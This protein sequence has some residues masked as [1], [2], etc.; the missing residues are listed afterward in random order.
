[1]FLVLIFCRS[2]SARG[3]K[4]FLQEHGLGRKPLVC[5][6]GATCTAVI[7]QG[8]RRRQAPANKMKLIRWTKEQ[9]I[10]LPAARVPKLEPRAR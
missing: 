7:V 4:S 2:Q 1:M 9:D 5:S 3:Y 8:L 10:V 6:P